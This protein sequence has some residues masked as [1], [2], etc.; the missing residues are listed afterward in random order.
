MT[1]GQSETSPTPYDQEQDF[2]EERC[3]FQ[4]GYNAKRRDEVPQKLW[5]LLPW[6]R[7]VGP[8]EKRNG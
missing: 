7:V 1:V 5:N 8:W 3:W 2:T 4:H 6:R